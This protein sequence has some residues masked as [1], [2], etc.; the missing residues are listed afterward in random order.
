M[1]VFVRRGSLSAALLVCLSAQAGAQSPPLVPLPV[2]ANPRGDA[3]NLAELAPPANPATRTQ[4]YG[5]A[6]LRRR[7]TARL[8]DRRQAY[9]CVPIY[10]SGVRHCRRRDLATPKEYFVFTPSYVSSPQVV[11]GEA[12]RPSSLLPPVTRFFLGATTIP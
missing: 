8:L 12:G 11:E 3:E 10:L 5:D 9:V 2:P 1:P 7:G 4:S 6:V